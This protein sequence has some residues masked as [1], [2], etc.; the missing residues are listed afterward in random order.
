MKRARRRERIIAQILGMKV[1][2][3]RKVGGNVQ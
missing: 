2:E 1:V 3:K